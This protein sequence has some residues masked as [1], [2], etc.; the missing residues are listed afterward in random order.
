[1]SSVSVRVKN[2]T[3]LNATKDVWSTPSFDTEMW[4][5]ANMHDLSTNPQLLTVQTAGY[6]LSIADI[7][8]NNLGYGSGLRYASIYVSTM[9]HGRA[10]IGSAKGTN[11]LLK[12][13]VKSLDYFNI[14][15]TIKLSVLQTSGYATVP[16]APQLMSHLLAVN[17][18]A[19]RV[20]SSVNISVP[21]ATWTTL[22][23][24]TEVF[25][26]NNLH[27]AV[28][29]DRLTAPADGYYLIIGNILWA[30]AAA[31]NGER[32][33][34]ILHSDGTLLA[35]TGIASAPGTAY[36]PNPITNSATM[37]YMSAGDYVVLQ[38]YQSE[39]SALNV[40]TS[41]LFPGFMMIRLLYQ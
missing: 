20:R 7:D 5:T 21:N 32:G 18:D 15:D 27:D 19:V 26:S 8:W 39:G 36:S 40:L 17:T 41:E 38:A 22:N 3:T 10:A 25:D 31:G 12:Q 1:M 30:L 24:D 16:Y 37:W 28:N 34:R 4:D 13:N 6:Y 2:S 29:P 33:S 14:G 11:S 9:A 35:R 23:F